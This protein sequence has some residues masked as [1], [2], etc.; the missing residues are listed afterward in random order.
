MTSTAFSAQGSTIE[1]ETGDGTPVSITGV[2]VGYPTI[3]TASGL[4][5]GDVVAI[6]GLTGTHAADLNAKSFVVLYSTGTQAALAVNTIG[7]TITAGSGT[8]TPTTYTAIANVKS[9]SGFDGKATI[10]DV[11]NLDSTAKEK[12]VGLQDFGKFSFEIHVDYDNAG[13]QALSTAKAAAS[14]KGF[15]L[16]YPNSKV[17]TFDA[18]VM[19]M[20]SQGGVDTAVTGSVEL[21]IS[22]AVTIA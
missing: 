17:A 15:R 9:F 14:I 10:I 6:A 1:I 22:G 5:N 8:A 21:E 18:Y 19:G 16:T 4:N 12:L 3:I 20:P 7:R 13:Q 11:T 2:S